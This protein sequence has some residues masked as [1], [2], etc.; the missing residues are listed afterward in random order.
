MSVAVTVTVKVAGERNNINNRVHIRITDRTD[1]KTFYREYS[2][3][4]CID[5]EALAVVFSVCFFNRVS[6]TSRLPDV[7]IQPP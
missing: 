5:K 2:S 6:G 3:Y 4:D 1:N 7:D